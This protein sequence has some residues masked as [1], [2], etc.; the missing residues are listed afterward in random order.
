[1]IDLEDTYDNW[2]VVIPW[3]Y[4]PPSNSDLF[5]ILIHLL[6]SGIPTTKTFK[7][8]TG[9][10]GWGVK[11]PTPRKT[12]MEPENRPLEKENHLPNHHFQDSMSIFQGVSYSNI[13]GF[14]IP[15][16][17]AGHDN[18]SSSV[19][20]IQPVPA[21]EAARISALNRGGKLRW[22][23]MVP[24]V[25]RLCEPCFLFGKIMVRSV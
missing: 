16:S 21:E 12:S 22:N 18:H 7:I 10:P 23:S 24:E 5:R 3:N 8:V 9:V 17:L 11:Q 14:P 20:D 19:F 6:G 25:P 1:M 2:N 15:S 4:P 13:F